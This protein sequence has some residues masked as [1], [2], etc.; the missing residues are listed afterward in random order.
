VEVQEQTLEVLQGVIQ[1]MDSE[2]IIVC[3]SFNL[4]HVPANQPPP[5]RPL[6]PRDRFLQVGL[7]QWLTPLACSTGIL[8]SAHDSLSSK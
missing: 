1:R 8:P 2:D 7:L 3:T 4:M 6:P 5:A